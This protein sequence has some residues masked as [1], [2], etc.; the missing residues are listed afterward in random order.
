MA[1][2]V[3]SE[4]V[5]EENRDLMIDPQSVSELRKTEEDQPEAGL[6]ILSA[7]VGELKK[8]ESVEKD[9]EGKIKLAF[10]V[11]P[12]QYN[13][14]DMG[15]SSI[16]RYKINLLP[17]EMLKRIGGPGGDDLIN[18]ILQARSNHMGLFGRPRESRFDIGFDL[19]PKDKSKLPKD[20]EG[21]K[22]LMDRVEKVKELIWTCGGKVRGEPESPTFS[23]LL[24]MITRDGLLYGRFALSLINEDGS[25]NSR[26]IAFRAADAGTIYKT[27]KYKI[28]DNTAR[29][30][31]LTY[32]KKIYSLTGREFNEKSYIQGDYIYA[33][34]INGQVRQVFTE[35]EMLVHNL[36]PVT[37]VEFQGY[38]LTPIDQAVHAITTHINITQHN[39]LYFQYGRAARGM[40]VV[41]GPGV[42]EPLLQTIRNLFSQNINSVKNSHRIPVFG[43]AGEKDTIE[44]K[45]VEMTQK[46]ME[47]QYL[48]DNNARVI[49]SAYQLSPDELPGYGHLSRGSN[50]QALSESNA[51]YKLTAARDVGLRPLINDVQDFLN[52]NLLPRIDKE[53]SSLF[54]LTFAG[55]DA[56]TAE[57]ENVRLQ[58]DMNVWMGMNDVLDAV[59]KDRLPKEM[60]GDFILNPIFQQAAEKYL[61]FG[62]ILEFFF[63]KKDASKDPRFDFY[64]NPLWFQWKQMEQ[65]EVQTRIQL[66][67]AAQQQAQAMMQPQQQLPASETEGQ[68]ETEDEPLRQNEDKFNAQLELD[69]LKKKFGI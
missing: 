6:N 17:D 3:K 67:M 5:V 41:R 49:L 65:Q 39:K 16:Y 21:M 18:A 19:V 48:S 25:P 13:T 52:R 50:S 2:K 4:L 40:V 64:Q 7:I 15:G 59:E 42:S 43:L 24:K 20:K 60:G 12:V 26:L 23:Q 31:A 8:F 51:E 35:N 63:N 10:D 37:N 56:E 44:W 62:Q 34:S 22:T 57:K 68:E 38:P 27:I 29:I 33:Q 61:T 55:L 28:Q 54:A 45:P 32:L 1:K 69:L 30:Q 58:N 66:L 14:T 47:F 9:G 36:Y 53:V 46:D 11:D